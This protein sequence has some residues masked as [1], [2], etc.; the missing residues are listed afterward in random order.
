MR[1]AITGSTGLIGSALVAAFSRDGHQVTRLIRART[2]LPREPEDLARTTRVLWDPASGQIDVAALEGHDVVINLAGESIGRGRWTPERKRRI[3]ESRV[4]STLFLS[5][6]LA[7]LR[8]PPRVFLSGSAVGYYG[9]RSPD[10]L[11]EEAA[12][13]GSGFSAQV[14]VEWEKA[15]IAAQAAGIR[16]IFLRNGYVLSGRGGYLAPLLPVFKLGLGG[17]FGSGRQM[18]SWIAIDDLTRAVAHV[19]AHDELS[20]PVNLGSPN[21]VTNAEFARTL[22]KVLKRP[23]LIPVPAIALR[24]MLGELAGDVLSGARM[25]PR[26]LLQSGFTFLYP[27]L[28][29][30]L[31]H[32]LGIDHPP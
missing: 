1:I 16:V 26:R 28:E 10:E 6:I 3:L 32:V 21:P 22:G 20:G 31:R 14:A 5:K 19:V 12:S 7:A 2:L 11:L 17:Q 9:N 30:A 15:T 18:L 27:H 24:L 25:V 23:A 13:P 4:Q 29:S 8:R